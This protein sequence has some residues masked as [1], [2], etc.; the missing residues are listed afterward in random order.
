MKTYK[1]VYSLEAIS[2]LDAIYYNIAV[3]S[4]ESIIA[5]NFIR[6]IKIA[7]ESLNTF[8]NRYQLFDQLFNVTGVIR[9]LPINGYIIV[10]KVNEPARIVEIIRII[11]CKRDLTRIVN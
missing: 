4:C 5:G 8:P 3:N 1:V 7:V 9:R 6:K 11:S 10:Y 2:D